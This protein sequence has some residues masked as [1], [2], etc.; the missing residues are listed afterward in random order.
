MYIEWPA[1]GLVGWLMKCMGASP[2]V[3]MMVRITHI[4][5]VYYCVCIHVGTYAYM[6]VRMCPY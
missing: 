6:F 5:C 3:Y 2:Y 1:R 4:I